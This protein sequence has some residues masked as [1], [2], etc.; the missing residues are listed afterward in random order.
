KEG[1]FKKYPNFATA[2]QQLAD[3]KPGTATQGALMG[4]FPEFRNLVQSAFEEVYAGKKDPQTAL[5]DA[6][7]K[8][9]KALADYNKLY[10]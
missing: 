4:I 9:N 1:W 7:A 6:A 5:N 8:A 2:F 3:S 10:Q